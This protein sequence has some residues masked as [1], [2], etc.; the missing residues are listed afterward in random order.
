MADL[1][2]DEWL[3]QEKQRLSGYGATSNELG[4]D[5]A[6]RQLEGGYQNY[7]TQQ[8][9]GR[10][11]D[12]F[13]GARESWYPELQKSYMSAVQPGIQDSFQQASKQQSLRDIAKGTQGGSAGW[14]NQAKLMQAYQTQLGQAQQQAAGMADQQKSQDMMGAHQMK[15]GAT[16]NPYNNYGVNAQVSAMGAQGQGAGMMGQMDLQSLQNQ[17]N[18]QNMWSQ[19]YG[20]QLG[21]IGNG[22]GLAGRMG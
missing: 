12:A 8:K 11:A 1:T 2:Q 15:I 13:L 10:E 3:G 22:I 7:L 17:Q 18:I 21:T 20:Q 14:L 4:S 6:K 16:N 19:L 9:T 5:G